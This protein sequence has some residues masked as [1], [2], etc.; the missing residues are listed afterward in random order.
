MYICLHI[1]LFTYLF[2]NLKE[3][4]WLG[5]AL[6]CFLSTTRPELVLI[7]RSDSTNSA[8]AGNVIVTSIC[9]T[10]RHNVVMPGRHDPSLH[11]PSLSAACLEGGPALP[12]T[13]WPGSLWW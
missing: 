1:Y 10:H 11:S 13:C 6:Y 4:N 7:F 9:H 5:W 3:W 12:T 2:T 8:E